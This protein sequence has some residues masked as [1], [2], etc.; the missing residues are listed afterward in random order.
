M[1]YTV[2]IDLGTTNIVV[3]TCLTPDE[4]D[5]PFAKPMVCVTLN[6]PATYQFDPRDFVKE[7]EEGAPRLVNSP[8]LPTLHVTKIKE[9]IGLSACDMRI[10]NKS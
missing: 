5:P 6:Y 9:F 4:G 2:G 3:A 8:G 10:V 1:T 7:E